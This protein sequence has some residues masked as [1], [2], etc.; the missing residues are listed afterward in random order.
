MRAILGRL[1]GILASRA[2]LSG[3]GY[4]LADI[5][6]TVNAHRVNFLRQAGYALPPLPQLWAWYERVRARPSFE[7]AIVE[8][9]PKA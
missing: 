5:S 8:W 2:W 4:G 7:R 3:A 6:W 1:D 9:E